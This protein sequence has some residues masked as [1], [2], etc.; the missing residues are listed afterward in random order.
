MKLGAHGS[1]P[2]V[3]VHARMDMGAAYLSRVTAYLPHA[4][5]SYNRFHIV[6]L[7]CEAMDELRSAEWKIESALV[8]EE[9]GELDAMHQ[10][11]FL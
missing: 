5:S 9:L 6:K 2:A 8:R 11:F 3:V 1:E 4:L 10:R 7:S